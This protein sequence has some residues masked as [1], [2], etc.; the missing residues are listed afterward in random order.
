MNVLTAM[1]FGFALDL[2]LGDPRKLTGIHP[3]VLMGKS[4]HILETALR[5]LFPKTPAGER[6]AGTVL[7][8]LLPAGVYCLCH[9][10]SVQAERFSPALQTLLEGVWCW[11]A[12]AVK[13]LK[14]EAMDV[15]AALESGTLEDARYAVSR[16]VGRDTRQLSKKGVICAAV[17]T[18]AENFSDGV[19]APL[20]YMMLGGAPAALAYKAINTMDSMIGY[21]NDRYRFFGTAAAK[22]DDAVNFIP[23]RLAAWLLIAASQLCVGRGREAIR[24]WKRDRKKHASPNAAQCESVMA[25]ALGIRLCGPA[26]Y[27]GILHDK[28]YIGDPDREADTADIACAC[29]LEV[30]GSVFALILFS[31]LRGTII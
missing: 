23:S 18:V 2:L 7:A 1:F 21:Q 8:I 24:I 19:V 28:P 20:F 29:H 13:D 6:F 10:L 15:S 16:I 4:I 12:L 30:A 3:V 11:Q 5:S 17:E 27:F 14:V 26:S 25:G 31:I 9:M 22:M